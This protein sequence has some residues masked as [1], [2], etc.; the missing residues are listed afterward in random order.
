MGQYVQGFADFG[1][2]FPSKFYEHPGVGVVSFKQPNDPDFCSAPEARA[3]TIADLK[4]KGAVVTDGFAIPM[5][6]ETLRDPL[7]VFKPEVPAD[8]WF[9]PDEDFLR[10]AKQVMATGVELQ[11]AGIDADGKPLP[12]PAFK[13]GG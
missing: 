10:I 12:K 2:D 6:I 3:E 13:V 1:V 9:Y 5:H 8:F 7:D 4:K 11:S